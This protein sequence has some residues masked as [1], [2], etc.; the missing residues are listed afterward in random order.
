MK[1][2]NYSERNTWIVS[3]SL[4]IDKALNKLKE[5]YSKG[6]I[7]LN[8][9]LLERIK[10]HLDVSKVKETIGIKEVE[11]ESEHVKVRKSR[12]EQGN[13]LKKILNES[14]SMTEQ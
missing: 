3:D 10:I 5:A 6:D 7:V 12:K 11:V 14:S 2:M 4:L 8:K 13:A 9:G 1:K